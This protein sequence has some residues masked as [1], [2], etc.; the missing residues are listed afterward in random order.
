MA[1]RSPAPDPS[2]PPGGAPQAPTG[3]TGTPGFEI[4]TPAEAGGEGSLDLGLMRAVILDGILMVLGPDGDP[5]P[6]DAVGAA[7]LQ[8]PD[9]LVRLADGPRIRA[10]RIAAVLGAQRGGRLGSGREGD[11]AWIEAMLGIGPRPAMAKDEDLLAE[12]HHVEIIAFGREMMITS[13]AGGTFLIAEARSATP[14][15]VR[16]LGAD[17]EP[18][19]L[20]EVVTRLLG[21]TDRRGAG[22]LRARINEVTLPDCRTR[23]EDGALIIELPEVGALHFSR[24]DPAAGQGPSV[25]V[26]MPD[27]DTATIDELIGALS[28]SLTSPQAHVVPHE[29]DAPT[30]TDKAPGADPGATPALTS[31]PGDPASDAPRPVPLAVRLPDGLG[32]QEGEVALVVVRRLPAGA[33][34]SAGVACD[35]GSWLLSPRDLGGLSLVPPSGWT[36]DLT[37]EV[38][39]IAV[40]DRDGELAR[41][42]SAMAVP[43]A[44]APSGHVPAAI[45]IA[46]DP[47]VLSAADAPLDAIIVRDLPADAMLSAGAYDPTI[48]GWV[49]LPRQAGALTVTPG[50]GQTEGFTLTLLGVRLADGGGRP[51]LLAKIPVAIR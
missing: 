43:L 37:L 3:E 18:V 10:A 31:A 32:A 6:P 5:V 2:R 4:G 12:A 49:L 15:S 24:H 13:P 47:R 50:T 21:R 34:L 19:A 8:Q 33:S 29:Q 25:S 11:A 1:V 46:I 45:P 16:L 42:S 14:A 41:V 17:G 9:A 44:S 7:A 36:R 39:A 26:F 28:R 22:D 30:S 27:G 35:D 23:L 20:G 40:R 51:R 38:V 48:D